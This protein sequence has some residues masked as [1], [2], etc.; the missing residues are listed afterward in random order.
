MKITFDY[1]W[2]CE[3]IIKSGNPSYK[4]IFSYGI[5][6]FQKLSNKYSSQVLKLDP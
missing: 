6:F 2:N 5:L 1:I 4:R 3:I